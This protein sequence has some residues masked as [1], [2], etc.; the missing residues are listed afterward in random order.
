MSLP[1]SD[2]SLSLSYQKAS[3]SVLSI[4]SGNM[5]A[6]NCTEHRPEREAATLDQSFKHHSAAFQGE[7]KREEAKEAV[8][9]FLTEAEKSMKSS[10]V[11]ATSTT[12]SPVALP[13]SEI[14][15]MP[16]EPHLKV[17]LIPAEKSQTDPDTA[18]PQAESREVPDYQDYI[19]S[20]LTIQAR[21]VYEQLGVCLYLSQAAQKALFPLNNGGFYIG[22]VDKAQLPHGFGARV[23]V[24]LTLLE[25]KWQLGVLHGAGLH[26]YPSGDY[27]Q[28][29]FEGGEVQGLGRFVRIAGASYEG[30]WRDSR[31]WGKGVETWADGSV[32]NG[33]FRDGKKEGVGKF[34][35]ADG[36]MYEGEFRG[37]R[38]E[39]KGKY[40]WSDGR[41]YEGQWRNSKMHGTGH[42]SWPDGKT[43]EGEYIADQ[44]CGCGTLRWPNGKLYEGSWQDNRMHGN[45]TMSDPKGRRTAGVWVNGML[46]PSE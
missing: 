29:N 46:K 43:Y 11:S 16:V 32:Y 24:D 41:V 4:A 15:P 28:G 18:F 7:G 30:E 5:G 38:L 25:G 40:V 42:F 6:C 33:C 34:R 22:D 17:A 12:M 27:Y 19:L 10:L 45:G 23:G 44:K 20:K 37:N 31:Q 39:G 9:D 14:T 26:L 8:F 1:S 13:I 21:N 35:W 2:V 3:I 36:S